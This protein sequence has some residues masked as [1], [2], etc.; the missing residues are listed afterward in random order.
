MVILLQQLEA[1]ANARNKSGLIFRV[2]VKQ[3]EHSLFRPKL[4][5]SHKKQLYDH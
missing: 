4:T 1:N 5:H 2:P 3:E